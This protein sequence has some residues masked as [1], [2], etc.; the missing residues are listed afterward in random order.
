MQVLL[1]A[2]AYCCAGSM[3]RMVLHC[4]AFPRIM[5]E[6]YGVLGEGVGVLIYCNP[7]TV[8]QPGR[9]RFTMSMTK[10]SVKYVLRCMRA[11]YESS[12][13]AVTHGGSGPG[14]DGDGY[15]SMVSMLMDKLMS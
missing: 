7:V 1:R 10:D 13:A 9:H 6:L 12:T 5:S 4:F 3:Q 11:V 2:P 14:S 8:V 15:R